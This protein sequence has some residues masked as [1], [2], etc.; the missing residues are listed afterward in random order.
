L[1]RRFGD[2]K[3]VL[4]S[5]HVDDVTDFILDRASTLSPARTSVITSVLRCFLRFL[6]Q[7]GKLANNLALSVPTA[8]N[9][10]SKGLPVGLDNQQ[11]RKL[12][13]CC[14]QTSHHGMRDYAILLLLARLGL[15]A[16]EVVRLTLEDINWEASDLLVRGKGDH[17]ERLPL[18]QD[19]GQALAKYL[20]KARPRSEC[21]RVFIRSIAPRQGFITSSTVRHVVE[22]ALLRANLHPKHRGAHLLRHSL[23]TNM[24]RQGASLLQ[25]GQ[26]LRHRQLQTTEVYARVD[27]ASLRRL[28]QPWPGGVR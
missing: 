23:A 12:L 25:I 15:R 21:R 6:Y 9:Q 10:R 13:R 17:Q 24:L 1:V 14:D 7:Q 3:L 8:A 20:E 28:A 2:K 16:C 11:V 5:L 4:E 26:V 18:L 27:L 22:R 19:V